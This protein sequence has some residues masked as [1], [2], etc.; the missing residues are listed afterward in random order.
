MIRRM[1]FDPVVTG[2]AHLSCA[3]TNDAEACALFRGERA[4][5]TPRPAC[6]V[7][8]SDI[9]D[10][11]FSLDSFRSAPDASRTLA[12]I[13][14]VAQ[15]ALDSAGLTPDMLRGSATGCVVGTTVGHQF[16][17]T[18]YYALLRNEPDTEEQVPVDRFLN[19]NPAE[20]VAREY[21]LR[22]PVHTVSNACS[23][24]A[25]AVSIAALCLLSGQ[26]E[27]MIAVGADELH[28]TPVAGFHVLG[29]TSPF[30]CRPFDSARAG[31]NL[32]EGAGVAILET[33]ECARRRGRTPEFALRGFGMSCD[34]SHITAPDATGGGMKRAF[35][36]ALLRAGIGLADVAF[37][38]AHGTGTVL[39][40][41]CETAAFAGL[42]EEAGLA[43]PPPFLST[44]R[45]TGH[46]LGAAGTLEFIF[47]MLML[48]D[49]FVPASPGCK[50]PDSA[51]QSIPLTKPLELCGEARFAASSSLAFGGTD[52]VLIAERLG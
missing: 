33:P 34:A 25:D 24:G 40:D 48:R 15:R 26:C 11:V 2:F 3:G 1:P 29:V 20:A 6:N 47:S 27:R 50:T 14:A 9:R 32:G 44:K 13:R 51:L 38:N 46:T 22:G 23:S 42:A 30:P 4:P 28:R 18:S 10:Q 36:N 31:L 39:N 17:D 45:L 8:C 19:G 52:A 35:R 16:T 37:I 43:A 21:D 5:E 49:G 7:I 41:R 12:M